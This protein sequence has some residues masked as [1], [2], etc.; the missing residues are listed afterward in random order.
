M[1]S[2]NVKERRC[3]H[4]CERAVTSSGNTRMGTVPLQQKPLS[5]TPRAANRGEEALSGAVAPKVQSTRGVVSGG[6][7][8][9]GVSTFFCRLRTKG[10]PK[11][12]ARSQ[13]KGRRNDLLATGQ[14]GG[15]A[16]LAAATIKLIELPTCSAC[17]RPW[18]HPSAACDE[19]TTYEKTGTG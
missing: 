8:V 9:C 10:R 14:R 6:V 17:V 7:S 5:L 4:Q 2:V 19:R 1:S 13:L 11:R 3:G 16:I 12:P 15:E 18:P